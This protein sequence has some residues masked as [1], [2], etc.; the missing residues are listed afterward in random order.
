MIFR[1][2]SVL[3]LSHLATALVLLGAPA[4]T[5]SAEVFSEIPSLQKYLADPAVFVDDGVFYLLA[6]GGAQDGRKLP[7]YRSA[8]LTDWEF[9]G[10]AVSPGPKGAWNRR[11]FWA[12]ELFRL[13]GR[14]YLYY[15]AMPEGTPKNTG[16]RVGVAVAD[17]PLGPYED[18]GVVVPHGSIDGSV[19]T[20]H[21]GGR[22]LLYTT[23]VGNLS[24]FPQ[25]QILIDRLVT[26]TQ[27][28]G[29]PRPIMN[30]YGWQEGASLIHHGGQYHLFFSSGG[31]KGPS[32]CVR[33][34]TAEQPTGPFTERSIEQPR[35]ATAPGM[36][37]PGHGFAW[38]HPD[39]GWRYTFHAWDDT[40][41][42]RSPRFAEIHWENGVPVFKP[43][44]PMPAG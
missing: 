15:T 6:T 32:Y 9:Q 39:G 27:V 5:W 43:M 42:R 3:L 35:V 8:N 26:P 31:W 30:Q 38:R 10:G 19:F 41:S 34:A 33:W 11:N 4:P 44:L 17:H 18:R 12:P 22:Y 24:G 16:N 13:D 28:E 1:F 14:Y 37:G 2:P 36:I 7:I 20:D 29:K 25:G 40:M 21:D 23:E